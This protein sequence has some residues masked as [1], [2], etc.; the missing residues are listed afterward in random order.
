MEY[1][2]IKHGQSWVKAKLLETGEEVHFEKVEETDGI[3][4]SEMWFMDGYVGETLKYTAIG[5][6]MKG[7]DDFVELTDIELHPDFETAK[8]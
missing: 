4:Y 3:E 6:F 7:S 8:V 2:T 5:E 1:E